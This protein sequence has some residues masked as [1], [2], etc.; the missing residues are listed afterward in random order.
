MTLKFRDAQFPVMLELFAQLKHGEMDG[1]QVRLGRLQN[2]LASS[3]K[4]HLDFLQHI[5]DL[6]MEEV[7]MHCFKELIHN[8]HGYQSLTD[9]PKLPELIED[10]P[11]NDVSLFS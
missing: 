5:D 8:H 1:V 4:E 6:D 3:C 9:I 11:Q 10:D 2:L 7:E